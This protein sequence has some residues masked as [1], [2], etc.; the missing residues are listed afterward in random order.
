MATFTSALLTTTLL[1]VTG[2]GGPARAGQA[3]T[4]AATL[5]V[6]G[7]YAIDPPHTFAYFNARHLIVGV[8][9]GRFDKIAG[10]ITV[11]KD[12]GACSLDVTLDVASISTQNAMRDEDLRGPGYF[13]AKAFPT[14]TYRGR[15]L[16]GGAGGVWTL[17]GSLTIRGV[18]L[19]VPLQFTFLGT[20]PAQTGKPARV[21]FHG[22]ASLKRGQ[23]GMT[24][25]LLEEL[26][27]SPGPG[28]D[29]MLEI[30]SEALAG[31]GVR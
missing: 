29:V 13:D 20:A 1:A 28:P 23:F 17:E 10:S 25:D 11:T 5:P 21:A 26:G 3:E 18:T 15:G 24:R 6:P 8:V 7:N 30:D 22:T 12:P 31:A 16:R 4:P 2:W 9:R 27:A 19:I 14:M